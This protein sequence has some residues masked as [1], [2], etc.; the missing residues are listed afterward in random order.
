MAPSQHTGA[1]APVTWESTWGRF[2]A[3]D[4]TGEI[5]D[6][7]RVD[8][9]W[10]AHTSQTHLGV[11]LTAEMARGAVA[12]MHRIETRGGHYRPPLPQRRPSPVRRIA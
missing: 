2:H 7:V 1:A 4:H 3:Y 6:A 5:G 8:D 9:G 11:Y 12:G 10:A